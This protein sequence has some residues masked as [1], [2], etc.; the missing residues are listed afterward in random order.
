MVI[1]PLRRGGI[2][3]PI[4]ILRAQAATARL[5]FGKIAA[6]AASQAVIFSP[7]KSLLLPQR[8]FAQ[9]P[10]PSVCRKTRTAS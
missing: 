4:T 2:A 8:K 6:A 9:R 1:S 5:F 7:R 3:V 10:L